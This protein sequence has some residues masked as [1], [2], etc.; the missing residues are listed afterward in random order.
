[1][2]SQSTTN[3]ALREDVQSSPRSDEVMI[4]TVVPPKTKREYLRISDERR[5]ELLRLVRTV[6]V[7]YRMY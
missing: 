6:T 3:E 4:D 5:I 1:M 7:D 2:A